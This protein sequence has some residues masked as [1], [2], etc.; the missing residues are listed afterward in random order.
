M[1]FG[2]HEYEVSPYAM[3]RELSPG[4]QDGAVFLGTIQYLGQFYQ[5]LVFSEKSG[6]M[7][8]LARSRGPDDGCVF[9]NTRSHIVLWRKSR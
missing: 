4:R 2:Q 9:E 3:L 5:I 1:F 6:K 7:S 8:C